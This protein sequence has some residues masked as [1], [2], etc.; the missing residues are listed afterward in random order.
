M[1]ELYRCMIVED[2]THSARLIASYIKNYPE[3]YAPKISS[4]IAY[5]QEC[6]HKQEYDLLFLDLHL[7][8]A[9]AFDLLRT[10]KVQC[11]VIL[12]TGD[13][14]QSLAAYELNVVDY[15]IKPVTRQRFEKA[16]QKVTEIIAGRKE[17]R[18]T[19]NRKKNASAEDSVKV[20]L[21]LRYYLSP[22]EAD[23]CGSIL[24]GK[25]P[26]EIQKMYSITLNTYKTHMK[27]IFSKTIDR[28]L[29]APQSGHGKLQQLTIFLF[30]LTRSG[31]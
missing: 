12:I 17:L 2:E 25:K 22:R 23:I 3:F 13:R 10:G 9:T 31:S 29:D 24:K 8:D 11:P 1:S 20:I 14:M 15:L 6:L 27:H 30:N 21:V 16:I 19:D 18:E 28:H 7:P 5:A 26:A 4:T